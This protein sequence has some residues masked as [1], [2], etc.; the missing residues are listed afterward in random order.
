MGRG[1]MGQHLQLVLYMLLFQTN[2]EYPTM[3]AQYLFVLSDT[4]KMLTP[5]FF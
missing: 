4:Q 5:K 2:K 1:P 3:I